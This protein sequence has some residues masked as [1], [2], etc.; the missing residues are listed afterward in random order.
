MV[1]VPPKT[2]VVL[3]ASYGGPYLLLS[4]TAGLILR[5]EIFGIQAR[6]QRRAPRGWRLVLIDRNSCV[7]LNSGVQVVDEWILDFAD[8]SIVTYSYMNN[9]RE[10]FDL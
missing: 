9:G 2:A 3:G 4:S 10:P 6:A 1:S 8:S 5:L 7:S